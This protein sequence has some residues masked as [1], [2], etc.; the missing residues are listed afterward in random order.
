MIKKFFFLIP[1]NHVKNL[2]LVKFQKKLSRA[3]ETEKGSLM[4]ISILNPIFIERI[5]SLKRQFRK[6]CKLHGKLKVWIKS[7]RKEET[8]FTLTNLVLTCLW[9]RSKGKVLKGKPTKLTLTPKKTNES[10]WLEH[11]L[12]MQRIITNFFATFKW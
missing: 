4:I 10:L 9:K 1:E 8:L 12:R 5:K 3:K 7:K 2:E 6:K 11:Y